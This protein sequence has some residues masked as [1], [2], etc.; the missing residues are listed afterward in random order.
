MKRIRL[1]DLTLGNFKGVKAFVLSTHGNDVK[2]YGDNATGKTTLFDAFV[3]LLFDKDSQNKKDFSIKTLDSNGNPLHGIEHEVEARFLIDGEELML[4][5]TYAEKWTK[6]RGSA[7]KQFSGHTTKYYINDVPSKKK[8]YTDKVAEIV[9]EEVFKLLTSPTYFNE[10]LHWKDRRQTLLEVC[11]DITDEEV[12]AGNKVLEKLPGILGNHTIE[13]KRK[14]ITARR[15][16]INKELEKIPI[17]IDEIQRN[18]PDLESEKKQALEE[19]LNV[20]NIQINEKQDVISDIRNGKAIIDKEKIIQEIEIEL[21]KIKRNHESKSKDSVYK[22][23]AKLQEEQSNIHI[24]KSKLDYLE[25]QKRMNQLNIE[26][27]TKKTDELRQKWFEINKQEFTHESECTCPTCGQDLPQEQV[28]GAREKALADFN[29][30]KSAKLEEI[31][32]QGISAKQ[33]IDSIEETITQID[34]KKEKIQ[35]QIDEKEA[36][37]NKTNKQLQAEERMVIDIT[38]NADYIEQLNKKQSLQQEINSLKESAQNDIHGIELEVENLKQLR[39]R[40]LEKLSK[41]AV[42]EQTKERVRELMKQ[43]KAL[44]AEFEQLE[45]ELYLTEEFIRSKVEM[46][47]QKINSKFKYARFKLFEQQIN[48]GLNEICETTYEG[49]P[50]GSGLNNAARINVGLDIIN[51]MSKHYGLQAPIFVDNAEGVTQ[52]IDTES[53]LISLIVSEQDKVLR[54]EIKKEESVVA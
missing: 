34:V 36:L 52:L 14:I 8:E 27:L 31:Q 28:L 42:A 51:T 17:R 19:K 40:L 4:R 20:I 48:G 21:L 30:K 47:E 44:A 39:M 50:Y 32:K 46:L 1:I 9:D 37:I 35:T 26:Q 12:I 5:K 23:K 13:E 49:V 38:E 24:F 18:T 25:Q 2:V 15:S 43:E 6:T 45:Q 33:Q 29:L 41:L 22:Y 3:W 54:V 11:G 16:E 53:Q 10:Q 7:E